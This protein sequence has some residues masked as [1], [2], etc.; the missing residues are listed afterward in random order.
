MTVRIYALDNWHFRYS[1]VRYH[2]TTTPPTYHHLPRCSFSF[3]H[4]V[5]FGG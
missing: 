3:F 4:T 5:R 2:P 1:R